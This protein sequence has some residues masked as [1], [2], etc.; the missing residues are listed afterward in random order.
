MTPRHRHFLTGQFHPL[1]TP[2]SADFSEVCLT[3]VFSLSCRSLFLTDMNTIHRDLDST[4]N[5]VAPFQITGLVCMSRGELVPTRVT[6]VRLTAKAM[7][8]FDFCTFEQMDTKN[9]NSVSR[10][11][12]CFC[13]F[14]FYG[15]HINFSRMASCCPVIHQSTSKLNGC[16]LDDFPMQCPSDV[17]SFASDD[18]HTR[19]RLFS[20]QI[21]SVLTQQM[22]DKGVATPHSPGV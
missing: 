21:R 13:F 15:S 2:S 9:E 14:F 8:S 17:Q 4:E 7:E 20:R 18:R 6:G 22:F 11:S 16:S 3:T 5:T 10:L 19:S 1:A 12:G